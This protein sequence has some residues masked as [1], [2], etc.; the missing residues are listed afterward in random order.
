MN[1]YLVLAT[2]SLII[3]AI[4]LLAAARGRFRRAVTLWLCWPLVIYVALALWE[5]L[6][7]PPV[8]DPFANALL[9][10]SLISA[11]VLIPWLL[12][13]AVVLGLAYVLRMF[14]KRPSSTPSEKQRPEP[15]KAPS[16]PNREVEGAALGV[17]RPGVS[18][19]LEQTPSDR[20]IRVEFEP[21]E[22]YNNLWLSPPRVIDVITGHII[23]DLWGQ[24]WDAR[25]EFPG[26]R[27]VLLE[28]WRYSGA[29]VTLILD[30]DSA[31]YGIL[32]LR[33][34]EG[35][36]PSAP[37]SQVARGLEEAS[38]RSTAATRALAGHRPQIAP[39]KAKWRAMLLV[40]MGMVAAIALIAVIA[41]QAEESSHPSP[42]VI[43]VPEGGFR[44]ADSKGNR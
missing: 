41:R 34:V 3:P 13:S 39:A 31:S 20:T 36:F 35:P 21:I 38:G 40:A 30:L 8:S 25:A 2:A 16:E 15:A 29:A 5:A 11:I 14:L 23:L 7:R 17:S 19:D 24:D 37:L 12:I 43:A 22:W 10:L 44:P 6:T 33:N 28:C 26:P 18:D 32:H 27:Q 42:E 4:Y 1:V 9:G